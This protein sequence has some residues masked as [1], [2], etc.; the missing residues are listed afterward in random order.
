VNRH[1]RRRAAARGQRTTE[2]AR[3]RVVRVIDTK[4]KRG[5][6]E[7]CSICGTDFPHNSTTYGGIDRT[8]AIAYVGDCCARQLQVIYMS[9]VIAKRAYDLP[10]T[11]SNEPLSTDEIAKAI[12]ALRAYIAEMDRM[13]EDIA[14]RAGI[15]FPARAVRFSDAPWTKDDAAW[16]EANPGRSHRLRSPF[17]GEYEG[18]GLNEPPSGYEVGVLVRQVAPGQRAC[19]PICLNIKCPIPDVEAVIHALFD[20]HSAGGPINTKE[21]MERAVEYSR[22]EE[23]EQ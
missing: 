6:A 7:A 23:T 21:L 16:F 4:I 3:E 15:S 19:M 10:M 12:T 22:A 11:S 20:L 5:A 17:P 9:G 1:E 18:M 2:A 13:T 8:G 14:K